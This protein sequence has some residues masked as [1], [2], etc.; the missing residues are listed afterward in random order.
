MR[1]LFTKW[2][3][4]VVFT[5]LLQN[6]SLGVALAQSSIPKSVSINF[7]DTPLHE[8]LTWL[9]THC[10]VK[11]SY[12]KNLL[13]D[14]LVNHQFKNAKIQDIIPVILEGT[15][16]T[17]QFV[18][19][20]QILV[21]PKTALHTLEHD[22]RFHGVIT[23]ELTGKPLPFA[24]IYFKENLQGTT[25][26]ENGFFSVDLSEG[27]QN[28]PLVF[29]FVGYAPKTL[30][31]GNYLGKHITVKLS[32]LSIV[33]ED[34]TIM[35][36]IPTISV[37]KWDNALQLNSNTINKLPALPFGTDPMRSLQ[38]LPGISAFDDASAGIRVR[39]SATDENM[40]L[41]D[42]ML[43]YNIDHFYGI[44]SAIHPGIIDNIK[45]Y[46]NAFPIEYS[47]R[48]A[49]VIEINTKEVAQKELHGLVTADF[50]TSQVVL[51][52]APS[53]NFSIMA[54]G[55]STYQSVGNSAFYTLT[56][57]NEKE[58]DAILNFPNKASTR[59]TFLDITPDFK[60]YDAYFKADWQLSAKDRFRWT[61]FKG[62]DGYEVN[63]AE[64]FPKIL[65]KREKVIDTETFDENYTWTNEAFGLNYQRVWSSEFKSS[66]NFSKSAYD[67]VRQFDF[68]VTRTS[69][70]QENDPETFNTN[71]YN[72]NT[73][74]GYRVDFK[75]TYKNL[76]FGY[77]LSKDVTEIELLNLKESTEKSQINRKSAGIQ[78]ALYSQY[79]FN[80]S[81]HWNLSVGLNAAHFSETGSIYWSPRIQSQYTI[82]NYFYLKGAISH[83]QQFL[84][85]FNA[86]NYFSGQQNFWQISNGYD[87]PVSFSSHAML[88]AN[89]TSH[90]FS[91]DVELYY[92][93]LEGI[94]EYAL[95]MPGFDFNSPGTPGNNEFNFFTGKGNV[96]GL[97][98]LLKKETKNY[99]G[100]IAYTLSSSNRIF[101]KINDGNP[102]PSQD[103]RRHQIKL[104]NQY[105]LKNWTFSANYF[106]ASGRP[107]IDLTRQ[108]LKTKSRYQPDFD[109]L[110]SR[111]KDY[112]RFDVGIQHNTKIFG[113]PA[114]LS[115]S[116]FNL[117]NTKNIKY[118]Q[119]IYS[120][121]DQ[122]ANRSALQYSIIGNDLL[123]LERS[124]NCSFSL[125]F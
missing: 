80:F 81:E 50:M 15:D 10:L 57:E 123:L 116:V 43:L 97:D 52:Y 103:D 84:R 91:L 76:T 111:I 12:S 28:S 105:Q 109:E 92:K 59:S 40:V 118:R 104:M 7:L 33:V 6:I 112:H 107:F 79:N 122:M 65:P 106:Y 113:Q 53:S 85:Q 44:F 19:K 13:K 5:C 120:S 102:Y 78:N 45:V 101:D 100:W 8:V 75:N 11:I 25:S 20:D 82:S 26:D 90:L 42:G 39:G 55:R 37:K 41:L 35:E 48:T 4:L 86:E 110:I 121:S 14:I 125:K 38:L 73:L 22:D 64:Q 1:G 29:S 21:G 2:M 94:L 23:D 36:S 24:N 46:K 56:R 54:A 61:F 27:L 114:S 83:Y 70:N 74:S 72:R 3:R 49:S 68:F 88:G 96:L 87:I 67:F 58:N 69:F 95:Q 63:Y 47:G 99:T 16:L 115:F 77:S 32:P 31:P 18:G 30:I 17:Y 119:F 51:E 93:K 66:F 34:V 62:R 117:F 124:L 9:E 60:F 98:L 89:L 108:I 71:V